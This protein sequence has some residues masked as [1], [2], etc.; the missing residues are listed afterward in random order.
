MPIPISRHPGGR[1]SSSPGLGKSPATAR[2]AGEQGR[3]ACGWG[4]GCC[5]RECVGT[6][7]AF[8]MDIREED[9]P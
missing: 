2:T 8:G 6:L 3:E 9:F 1:V 5:R 4:G 7:E